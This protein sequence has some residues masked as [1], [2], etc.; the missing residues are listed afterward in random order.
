VHHHVR[1]R[2]DGAVQVLGVVGGV[3]VVGRR[4][5]CENHSG[6]NRSGNNQKAPDT[7]HG[8]AVVGGE[9]ASGQRMRT[10]G[11]KRFRHPIKTE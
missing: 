1:Q 5:T 9:G 6:N 11:V 4:A 7:S 8:R 10:A 3:A 2:V